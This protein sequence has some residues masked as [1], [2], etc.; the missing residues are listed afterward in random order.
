MY[1]SAETVRDI[2][3]LQPG[4]LKLADVATLDAWL[5]ARL[6]EITGLMN[7]D[8]N[9]TE[10]NVALLGWTETWDGIANRWC[11]EFVRFVQASRDSPIVKV[12]DFNVEVPNDK[13]P[14]PGVLKDLRRFPRM[15]SR[16][17]VLDMTVIKKPPDE[18]DET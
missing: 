3:G 2:T 17:Q 8:R 6:V 12:D 1:G 18:E 10:A 15:F 7:Q 4:D 14:G 16:R 5:E 13:V 11:A 9:R